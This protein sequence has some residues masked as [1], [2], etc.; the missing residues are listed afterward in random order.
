MGL[1]NSLTWT[2]TI[3]FDPRTCLCVDVSLDVNNANQLDATYS[4]EYKPDTWDYIGYVELYG[5]TAENADLATEHGAK[6]FEVYN[7]TDFNSLPVNI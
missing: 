6:Q 2:G 5:V 4:F 7:T 1:V 3:N